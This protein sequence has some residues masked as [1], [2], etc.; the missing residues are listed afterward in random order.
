M[1]LRSW[2]WIQLLRKRLF[3]GI[4]MMYCVAPIVAPNQ[5]SRIESLLLRLHGICQMRIVAL[6]DILLHRTQIH[7]ASEKDV[8]YFSG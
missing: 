5:G 7:S 3:L 2:R 6:A 4:G 1:S 8:A